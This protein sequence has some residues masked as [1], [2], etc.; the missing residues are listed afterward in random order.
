LARAVGLLDGA[1]VYGGY[2]LVTAEGRRLSGD[3]GLMIQGVEDG[4]T[5]T[6]T[7]GVDEP[8]PIVYDDVV[9]AMT[10]VVERDLKPWEPA[11]GRRTALWSAALL[12]TLGAVALLIQGTSMAA[13]RC[14]AGGVRVGDR[15]RGVE[16]GAERAR[17]S[18]RRRVDG[19][20]VRRHRGG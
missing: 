10:D 6:V 18:S 2:H 1:T 17:G 19:V 20:R 12:L 4:G 5:L 9:E 11:S 14:R 13:T 3:G 7:A 15:G 8:T 16:P